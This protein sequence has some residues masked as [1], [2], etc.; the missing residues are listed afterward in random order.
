MKSSDPSKL[1]RRS[2]GLLTVA[3]LPAFAPTA[4]AQDMY[5]VV[6]NHEEQYSIWPA[7]REAP[8]GWE[9]AGHK[10]TQAHCR[11]Y[12]EEVWTDMRPLSL[13]QRMAKANMPKNTTTYKV[14]INH[15]EQYSMWL[16]DQPMPK[17]W[18]ETGETC[19]FEACMAYIEEVWTDMRPLSLRKKM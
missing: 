18:R 16:P 19:T 10:G 2:A 5:K 3:A 11:A 17:Q 4:Q 9:Y 1:L 14:V 13:R 6:I 7:D 15:E 12:I 8:E